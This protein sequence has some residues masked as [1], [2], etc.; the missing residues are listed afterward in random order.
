M[1]SEPED[2]QHAFELYYK[3]LYNQPTNVDITKIETFLSSLD[4]PSIG[5]QQNKEIMSE[6]TAEELNKAIL[7]LKAKKAPGPDGY[8]SE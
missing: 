8:P 3:K 2:I 6:I 4:L 7:R 1:S 5:E